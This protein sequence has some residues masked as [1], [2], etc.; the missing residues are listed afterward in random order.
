MKSI[1]KPGMT[2]GQKTG[3]G[4]DSAP[5]RLT[6]AHHR[7]IICLLSFCIF[8]LTS[9]NGNRALASDGK[10]AE[11]SDV[12]QTELENAVNHTFGL[13][14]G[15]GRLFA[16]NQESENLDNAN[17]ATLR[18]H[19]QWMPNRR[20]AF[21][22]DYAILGSIATDP[23]SSHDA[24]DDNRFGSPLLSAERVFPLTRRLRLTAGAGLTLPVALLNYP[25]RVWVGEAVSWGYA[26]S[27]MSGQ[28]TR[29]MFAQRWTTLAV[30]VG[31]TY[32]ASNSLSLS[33]N[34]SAE[35]GF[36]HDGYTVVALDLRP[37]LTVG[38]EKNLWAG[39]IRVLGYE[40]LAEPL[41]YARRQ[42]S[43]EIGSAWHVG[44][45]WI[46]L[47]GLYGIT[48]GDSQGFHFHVMSAHLEAMLT[49]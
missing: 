27:A 29:A 10:S 28:T 20:W 5:G 16:R 8:L 14:G 31:I 33:F 43:A 46:R 17:V 39:F 48:G 21:G 45:G 7:N 13:E 38:Y 47:R 18:G 22:V 23:D 36:D 44:R 37:E 3:Q 6:Q 26:F 40:E 42:Y 11:N 25:T 1:V 32:S 9:A 41:S 12:P 34:L 30:P 4:Q 24:E 19:Y 2:R 15:F 35:L 49:F